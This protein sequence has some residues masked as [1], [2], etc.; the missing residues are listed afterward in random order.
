MRAYLWQNDMRT[1]TREMRKVPNDELHRDAHRVFWFE[2]ESRPQTKSLRALKVNLRRL[3]RANI[4]VQS[5]G[6]VAGVIAVALPPVGFVAA[7]A[8]L[9]TL[10]LSDMIARYD[11]TVALTRL[12]IRSHPRQRTWRIRQSRKFVKMLKECDRPSGA[13]ILFPNNAGRLTLRAY[14]FAERLSELLREAGWKAEVFSGWTVTEHP[15]GIRLRTKCVEGEPPLPF[16]DLTYAFAGQGIDV[17]QEEADFVAENLVH[18]IIG[19]VP[20]YS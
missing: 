19:R 14:A 16:D 3:R 1:S 20:D 17:I 13:I 5:A 4:T 8:A 15:F 9:T 6:V 7:A 11:Q 12:R 10:V 18:I 2:H